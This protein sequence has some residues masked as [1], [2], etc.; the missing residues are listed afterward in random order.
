MAYVGA[1][2]GFKSGLFNPVVL[3]G[4]GIDPPVAPEVLDAYTVGEKADFLDHRLRVNV[5]G[6]WYKYKNIQVDEVLSGVTHITNAAAATIKGVDLD[7]TVIPVEHLT[8]TAS[9][10]GLD[11]TYDSYPNG[12]FFAYNPITGGN[13][14]FLPGNSGGCLALPP[15]YN[16]ATGNWDLKGNKTIQTPPFSSSLTFAYTANSPTGEYTLS[17]AWNHT[18]NY[19]F[20]ADNGKGQIAPSLPLNDKQPTVNLLNA[21]V[22]WVSNDG[23]WS[24]RVWGKN[25]TGLQ[26]ISFGLEDSFAT[27]DSPAPPRTFGITFGYKL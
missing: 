10:E 27:Q 8:V 15:N 22:S 24:A 12:T 14:T 25:L 19:Y 21:S 26:Y 18:G 4:A 23:H 17:L 5:E 20:D 3:P 1:N 9:L 6:F 7:V 11:G 2:R 13:C 16:A